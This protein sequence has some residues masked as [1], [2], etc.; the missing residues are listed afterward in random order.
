MC[1]DSFGIPRG[2][3]P[4]ANRYSH[5]GFHLP[6]Y[7]SNTADDSRSGYQWECHS[8]LARVTCRL[9]RIVLHAPGK[10]LEIPDHALGLGLADPGLHPA[11][12]AAFIPGYLCRCRAWRQCI[13]CAFEEAVERIRGVPC[14]AGNS[15]L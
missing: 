3:R 13:C 9:L 4:M 14:L 7:R 2:L 12:Q 6:G 10:K 5:A 15:A 1:L 8:I 11:R